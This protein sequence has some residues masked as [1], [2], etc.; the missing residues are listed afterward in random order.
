MITIDGGNITPLIISTDV[1]IRW[2]MGNANYRLSCWVKIRK[3]GKKM[4]EIE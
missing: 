3:N 4:C 2:G 1:I